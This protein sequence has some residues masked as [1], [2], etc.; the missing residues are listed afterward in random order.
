VLPPVVGKVS[1]YWFAAELPGGTTAAPADAAE[2]ARVVASTTAI[3]A[4]K[5]F[6]VSTS[7]LTKGRVDC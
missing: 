6:E 3:E 7:L 2:G 4:S 1:V 5:V